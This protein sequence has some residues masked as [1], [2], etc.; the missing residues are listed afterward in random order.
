MSE[1]WK[2]APFDTLDPVYKYL[3]FCLV[4][5]ERDKELFYTYKKTYP[6]FPWKRNGESHINEDPIQFIDA[7]ANA[8]LVH[9]ETKEQTE[10]RIAQER[11][12]QGKHI[13]VS[14]E[15]YQKIKGEM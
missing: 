11:E 9:W 10:E 7:C 14:W 1:Y 5:E 15:R 4:V 6:S 3:P 13:P 12:K 8:G 2:I